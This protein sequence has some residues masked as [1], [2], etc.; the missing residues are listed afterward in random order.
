[1]HLNSHVFSGADD[2][3]VKPRRTG[4]HPEKCE[5]H[6][7][8]A[9]SA[10]SGVQAVAIEHQPLAARTVS[11]NRIPRARRPSGGTH[12]DY[13]QF[14][15]D[16]VDAGAVDAG[17][18][19][20]ASQMSNEIK[21]DHDIKIE[22]FDR[23]LMHQSVE[24]AARQAG[25]PARRGAFVVCAKVATFMQNLLRRLRPWWRLSFVE[26]KLIDHHI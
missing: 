18:D 10:R 3:V 15:D 9:M 21:G 1:M 26:V 13:Q 7:V 5:Q 8:E 20:D 22:D 11:E 25:A 14:E 16:F 12:D 24:L 2:E 17:D 4:G 19:S 23:P 6:F